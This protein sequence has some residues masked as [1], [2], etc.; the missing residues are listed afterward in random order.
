MRSE[1]ISR[2]EIGWY[3][4][5]LQI[6]DP[7]LIIQFITTH[8]IMEIAAAE[9]CPSELWYLLNPDCLGTRALCLG[10]CW[11]VLHLEPSREHI[12]KGD[13]NKSDIFVLP[14]KQIGTVP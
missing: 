11:L 6:Q 3:G 4:F 14:V 13:K 1:K 10:L 8:T 7:L 2:A 5:P 9:D 12:T